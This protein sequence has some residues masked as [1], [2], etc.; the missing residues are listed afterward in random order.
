MILALV[1]I[2]ALGWWI[3]IGDVYTSM[4]Y[5][6]SFA[7]L[8]ADATATIVYGSIAIAVLASI[9]S[10]LDFAFQTKRR[11]ISVLLFAVS[12][13]IVPTCW[14]YAGHVADT[15]EPAVLQSQ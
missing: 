10:I 1:V 12:A 5:S 4:A 11:I 14:I 15:T 6:N 3:V 13:L 8:S 2:I 9:L 7:W